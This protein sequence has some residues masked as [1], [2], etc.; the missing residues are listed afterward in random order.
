MTIAN[1]GKQI[2]I[3][4]LVLAILISCGPS[5]GTAPDIASPPPSTFTPAAAAPSTR[6][7]PPSTET[8][9]SPTA[10]R[11]PTNTWP[12]VPLTYTPK[13][14]TPSETPLPTPIPVHIPMEPGFIGTSLPAEVPP[15][16]IDNFIGL[17]NTALWGR[18]AIRSVAFAPDGQ[19]FAVGSL[20]GVALYSLQSLDQAPRWLLLDEP[21]SYD[22]LFFSPNGR[23]LLLER[24]NIRRVLDLATG[25]SSRKIPVIQWV[26]P[27]STN[28]GGYH[29]TIDSPDHT[30][31]LD[32]GVVWVDLA[33]VEF[34]SLTEVSEMDT[35]S[36]VVDPK[37]NDVLYELTDKLPYIHYFDYHE[38][39]GCEINVFSPCGNALMAQAMSP[40]RAD[41]SVSGETLAVLYRPPDLYPN[42]EFSILR[43]YQAWDG[44]LISSIGGLSRPVE[45]FAYAPDGKKLL[46]GF[47][48][49]SVQLWDV[50]SRQPVFQS[51]DFNEPLI[52]FSETSD[53]KYLL[54]RDPDSLKVR[55]SQDGSLLASL[56][57]GEFNVSPTD[58]RVAV[59]TKD[60]RI[61]IYQLDTG[62]V[63]HLE[64]HQ[65]QIYALAFS[66]DGR[67]LASASQD[68]TVRYWDLSDGHFV[69]YFENVTANPYEFDTNPSRIFVH[70]LGFIP[71][72]N[73]LV[74]FGSWGTLAS[75]NVTSGATQFII[76][77]APL[78]YFQGMMTVKPHFPESAD[79]D[80]AG[81]R[82]IVQDGGLYDLTTG[83]VLEAAGPPEI[84]PEGCRTS[85]T[86]SADGRLIFSSG[87]YVNE[88]RICVLEAVTLHLLQTI[89]IVPNDSDN[90]YDIGL[91]WPVL[92]SDGTRIYLPTREG[93]L[94][95][96]QVRR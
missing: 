11:Q 18:G 80:L 22:H 1:P 93:A 9:F 26:R 24:Q 39:E 68:C 95:V 27:A 19:S 32:G 70:D 91:G 56:E 49:G 51:V 73:Q 57:A 72:T 54:L 16:G 86:T 59:G 10:T 63:Q 29:L 20:F 82:F 5:L 14:Y 15:I 65:D 90:A 46:V 69:H 77:S 62:Q 28:D 40:F 61:D 33:E 78:K 34:N 81:E 4:M 38:P 94:Y 85:G 50:P 76:P 89:E 6:T 8:A 48:D 12:P 75:W 84:K 7:P 71:G 66:P 67:Y 52:G 43:V 47:G 92:S 25:R 74:G 37:T 88:G 13:G 30:R 44:K 79:L 17:I 53:G 64:G 23:L 58:N 31:T 41:F 45:D 2:V 42:N 83:A 60:G 87:N 96:F 21:F 36:Q 55:L 3:I 35:V